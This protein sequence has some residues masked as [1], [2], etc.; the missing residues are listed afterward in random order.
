[1]KDDARSDDPKCTL[2]DAP[3]TRG[4]AS[5]RGDHLAPSTHV[6]DDDDT[7]RRAATEDEESENEMNMRARVHARAR[8]RKTACVNRTLRHPGARR[9]DCVVDARRGEP[10]G[11]SL[12]LVR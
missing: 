9:R 2:H 4:A 12:G 7:E 3:G 6:D 11:L 10:Q 1:V 5:S 8:E